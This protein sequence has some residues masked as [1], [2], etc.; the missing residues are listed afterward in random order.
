[1]VA[2]VFFGSIWYDD[3]IF[4]SDVFF[5]YNYNTIYVVHWYIFLLIGSDMLLLVKWYDSVDRYVSNISH[6][7][8]WNGQ[9]HEFLP[10][11]F[12]F[13]KQ[14]T[15]QKGWRKNATAVNMVYFFC[16]T[17]LALIL[18]TIVWQCFLCGKQ[19]KYRFSAIRTPYL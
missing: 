4:F 10:I 9:F 17:T 3:D 8:E 2:N 6:I 5:F 12:F 16:G 18:W 7:V 19:K 11:F 1:M 14:I 15:L 13:K